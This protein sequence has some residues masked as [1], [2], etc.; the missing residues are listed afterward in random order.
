VPLEKRLEKAKDVLAKTT[1]AP[2]SCTRES[3]WK[4]YVIVKREISILRFRQVSPKL[5]M[6]GHQKKFFAE[7]HNLS[8]N[9]MPFA[10]KNC[11]KERFKMNF[12][13]GL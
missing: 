2:V 11:T 5:Q 1:A 6:G 8:E 7:A 9:Q 13:E 10:D 3:S 12:K 4:T